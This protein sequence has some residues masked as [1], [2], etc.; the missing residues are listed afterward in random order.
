MQVNL[1]AGSVIRFL[2]LL[3]A[4]ITFALLGLFSVT[5][6]DLSPIRHVSVGLGFLSLAFLVP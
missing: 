4:V 6:G 2:L 3:A 1:T 5:Y